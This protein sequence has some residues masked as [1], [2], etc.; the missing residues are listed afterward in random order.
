MDFPF[1]DAL[2]IDAERGLLC[3]LAGTGEF[4]TRCCTKRVRAEGKRTGCCTKGVPGE[5]ERPAMAGQNQPLRV[6]I[7]L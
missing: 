6:K 4:C 1:L 3:N 5:G 7:V 2:P